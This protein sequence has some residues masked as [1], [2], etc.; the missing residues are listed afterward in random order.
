MTVYGCA[1]WP[2][3]TDEGARWEPFRAMVRDGDIVTVEGFRH[4]SGAPIKH[5][6]GHDTDGRITLTPTP[7]G[8]V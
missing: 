1:S 4:P 2:L 5:V 3:A 7:E 8:G 6:V